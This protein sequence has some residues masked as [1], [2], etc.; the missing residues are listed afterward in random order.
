MTNKPLEEVEKVVNKV[1]TRAE[2]RREERE[3]KDED[4]RRKEKIKLAITMINDVVKLKLGVFDNH[5]GVEA[6]RNIKEGEKLYATAIPCLVDVPYKDL[7]KI[8]PDIR[9]IIL[10]RFP[11]V[12]FGSHFMCPDTL[13][14]MYIQHSDSPNYDAR[15]DKSLRKIKKG[16]EITQDYSL[17]ESSHLNWRG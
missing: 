6:M 5:V 15:S 7:D 13:M 9:E 11:Q 16:E 2:K 14:Q 1:K 4:K 17:I 12:E 8:R 10:S 3:K